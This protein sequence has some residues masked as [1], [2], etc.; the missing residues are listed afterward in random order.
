MTDLE[1]A[2][3]LATVHAGSISKAAAELYISPSALSRRIQSLEAELG[4]QLFIRRKGIRSV[5]LTNAGLA[6]IDVASKWKQLWNEMQ[7]IGSLNNQTLLNISVFNS[8]GYCVMPG[9]F[10]KF[11]SENPWIYLNIRTIPSLDAFRYVE[12]GIVD[13]ALFTD[14][15]YIANSN[16][17]PAYKESL[18]VV[19][20]KVLGYPRQISPSD[21]KPSD[22]IYMPWNREYE[23]WYSRWFPSSQ[24]P[25]ICFNNIQLIEDLLLT[26]PYWAIIPA[27][28]AAKM[29][30]NPELEIHTIKNGPPDRIV[31]YLLGPYQK[32]NASLL[33][34]QY[35]DRHIRDNYSNVAESLIDLESPE[36]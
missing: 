18:V 32:R 31:Y 6:F 15:S 2:A 28:A 8:I 13:L 10:R 26:N 35:F 4:Y 27:S 36:F 22:H 9:F 7:D 30:R 3:F 14:D 16:M 1:V 20:Q 25:K 23:A 24:R 19:C 5:E 11:M 29:T 12:N 33:F 34:L 21:L 17:R